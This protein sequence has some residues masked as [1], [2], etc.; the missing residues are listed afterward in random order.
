[1]KA[2]IHRKALKRGKNLTFNEDTCFEKET[3]QSKETTKNVG[4]G[5][6]GEGS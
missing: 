4:V 3:V 6:N 5:L 2:K 1:M